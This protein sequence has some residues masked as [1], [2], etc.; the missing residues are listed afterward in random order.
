MEPDQPLVAQVSACGPSTSRR[1]FL[2]A[3]LVGLSRKTD[4]PITGSFVDDSERAGHR[5]RS[6]GPFR[7]PTEEL[8]VPLVIVGGGMAGLSAA[9][10]LLKRGFRD[11]LL[12]E[13]EDRLGG[14]SRWGENE[15]SAYPWGAHYVPVPG[16]KATLI[17]E[18][19]EDLGVLAG[20]RFDE[21]CLCHSPQER[22]FLHGRWQEGIEPVVG[23]TTRD[24]EQYR[25]FHDRL[26]EL[27]LTGQFTIPMERGARASP[28]DRLSMADWLRRERFDSPYLLWYV[29]YCCRDDYGAL[30]EDVSAWAGIHYFAAREPE[31]KGPLTW[32]EGNGWI[33]R[34]LQERLRGHARTG[35]LVWRIARHGNRLRVFTET[36][37]CTAEAVIFA[38]PTFL[39]AYLIEEAPR[40]M[41]LEYS[42]WLTANLTLDRWPRER[43]GEPAWDNVI[44]D[45]P[46]LGYVVATHQRLG[47]RPERSVWTYYWALAEGPPARNRKLLLETGWHYW[48]EA[49]LNDLGRAHPDIRACVSRIDIMRLGHAMPRPVPG[50]I[51]SEERRRL[52]ASDGNLWFAHSDLSG[53]SIV[54]EA[55]YRGV[56]AADRALRRLGGGR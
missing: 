4:R 47:W 31:E 19:L 1:L 56:E 23:A 42:P 29:N 38:A 5:I 24:R 49:I 48:K 30:A 51:F 34:R 43:A 10:R 17:R 50:F 41:R 9:W 36:A 32:P 25:R 13:M 45:S 6:R 40:V 37:V 55:Q 7:A 20:G 46:A 12:L 26:E 53:F 21:R 11:F 18:L 52:A 15:V 2:S 22:L 39:A 8:R 35:A 3:A 33:V 27:R 14:V 44:Y 28:L 16:P 54:E